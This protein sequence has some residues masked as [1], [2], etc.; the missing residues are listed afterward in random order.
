MYGFFHEALVAY[1]LQQPDGEGLVA[2]LAELVDVNPTYCKSRRTEH[3]QPTLT[4]GRESH[5]RSAFNNGS[6]DVA[7]VETL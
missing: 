7:D 2:Q 5:G 1:V 3:D 4:K 6:V